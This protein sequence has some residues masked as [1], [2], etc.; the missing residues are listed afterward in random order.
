MVCIEMLFFRTLKNHG[1]ILGYL[2]CTQ[3]INCEL[4]AIWVME[5]GHLLS[6]IRVSQGGDRV[7]GKNSE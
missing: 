3:L 1:F 4:S 2:W 7:K 5:R 6:E